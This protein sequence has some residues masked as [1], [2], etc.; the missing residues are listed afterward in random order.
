MRLEGRELNLSQGQ[1]RWP[2]SVGALLAG[3]SV[4]LAAYASHAAGD[5]ARA[6][7]STAAAFAFG[8]GV[9][10]IALARAGGGRLRTLASV[11]LLAGT[12]LFSGALVAKSVFGLPSA[13][14]PYG[15]MALMLGWLLHAVAAWRGQ[16]R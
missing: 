7:L 5:G 14:A 6:N 1:M 12:L 10:L 2:V 16:A 4:A 15:G 3:L 13:V 9:A 11:L 8:H